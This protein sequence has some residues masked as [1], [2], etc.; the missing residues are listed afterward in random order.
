MTAARPVLALLLT[1]APALAD[2]PA[3]AEPRA[4]TVLRELDRLAGQALWPGFE[5]RTIAVEVYDGT[6]TYLF[7]HPRPPEGFVAMAG[8]P[9]AF[10]SPGRHETVRANTGTEVNGIATATA[11][12]SSSQ[13]SLS[14][15]AALLLHEAFHV[16]EKRAHPEWGTNEAALFVYP[17]DD[18]ELLVARRLETRAL[19]RA[20]G[21]GA[22]PK[23][24]CSAA[25]AL[26]ARE[27][28]AA[29]LPKD[30]IAYERGIE[31]WEGL[32][33]YV[34][35]RSVGRAPALTTADFPVE[36]IRQ[37]GYATG[38]AWAVLL[39][40]LAPGWESRVDRSLDE[41]LRAKLAGL[42]CPEEKAAD[43]DDETTRAKRDVAELVASRATRERSFLDAPGGRL[44]VVAGQEPLWPQAFDPWNLASLGG[45]RVLHTRWLKLRNG[46]GSLEVLNHA[47]LTEGVGPHPLF[48]G[49][50]RL[51][52]TGLAEPK[53][54]EAEGAVTIDVE[55]AKGRFAGTVE[56]DGK[57]VVVRV[58]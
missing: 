20:L 5:P 46:S 38:Q 37:R 17:L 15:Q 22:G 23:A 32:A 40:R 48:N 45:N 29:S 21:E 30:A 19:V 27:R 44:E 56:R 8:L 36:L 11:D 28:R 52:V 4:I 58:R 31:L 12:L 9:G 49:A 50:K 1:V 25:A 47:S 55:G 7:H 14:E 34:E 41:L 33:Q 53:V 3:S 10:V 35:Y 13:G 54:T 6:S 16:Y 42:Q 26:A 2:P 57:S 51:I 24:A 43:V 39:D 18:A